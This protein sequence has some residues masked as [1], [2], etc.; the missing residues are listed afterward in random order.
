MGEKT[1]GVCEKQ[2]PPLSDRVKK[3]NFIPH[4]RKVLESF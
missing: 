2:P 4:L 3:Q 1:T